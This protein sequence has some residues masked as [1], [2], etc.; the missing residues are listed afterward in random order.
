M[1]TKSNWEK[2]FNSDSEYRANIVKDILDKSGFH[3][4]LLKKKDSSYNNFGEY[5]VIV[6][7][8]FVIK[9]L[10]IISDEITFE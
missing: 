4:V 5:E 1:S 7:S 6:E 9:A 8:E 3:P 10:K 2:V